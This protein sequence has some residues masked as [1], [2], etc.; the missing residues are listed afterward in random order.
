MNEGEKQNMNIP[1]I[2]S[3][4]PIKLYLTT[5]CVCF[6]RFH[7]LYIFSSMLEIEMD[8]HFRYSVSN[9][10][11]W[12]ICREHLII[13]FDICSYFEVELLAELLTFLAKKN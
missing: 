5:V 12:A 13:V 2:V 6:L 8:L 11:F 9:S 1:C 3:L 4:S 10:R 7:K